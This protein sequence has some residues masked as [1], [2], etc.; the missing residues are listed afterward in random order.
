MSLKSDS[1]CSKAK[2]HQPRTASCK[3]S[4]GSLRSSETR[5]KTSSVQGNNDAAYRDAADVD[6]HDYELQG[7]EQNKRFEIGLSNNVHKTSFA[8][9]IPRQAGPLQNVEP[10]PYRTGFDLHHD[11]VSKIL[12]SAPAMGY[13]YGRGMDL[14]G[15]TSEPSI[16][17]RNQSQY[18][19]EPAW[20]EP[21]PTA[22][23][24]GPE[25]KDYLPSRFANIHQPEETDQTWQAHSDRGPQA[26]K[27]DRPS[28]VSPGETL[29]DVYDS[30]Y[31]ASP[32]YD[33]LQGQNMQDEHWRSGNGE[34]LQS[35]RAPRIA[36]N[37]QFDLTIDEQ[38][39]SSQTELDTTKMSGRGQPWDSTTRQPRAKSAEQPHQSTAFPRP[40][41]QQVTSLQQAR[42]LDFA[43]GCDTPESHKITS[44]QFSA[45]ARNA[46]VEARP[47][48]SGPYYY[49]H[50][51]QPMSVAQNQISGVRRN[52]FRGAVAFQEDVQPQR[53]RSPAL[54]TPSS[55][56]HQTHIL[57]DSHSKDQ[58]RLIIAQTEVSRTDQIQ[59]PGSRA[60]AISHA[61]PVSPLSSLSA[62]PDALPQHPSP[63]RPGLIQKPPPTQAPKPAPVRNYNNR[64]SA[65]Q[66]SDADY[67]ASPSRSQKAIESVPITHDE[68]D[69][70]KMTTKT[71]PSDYKTQLVLAKKMVEAAHVLADE[72]GR[73][74][75]K[76]RNKNREKYIFEAHKLV[77][78]LVSNGYPDAMFYLGDCHSRGLLGLAVDPKDAF[79]LYQS[80]AKAGHAQAAYRVAVCCEMGQEEG[81]GT[82]RDPLKAIQWYKRAATLGDTPAM[83]KMGMI[84]L[85]GLLAQAK[86]PKDAL[87][88]LKRA[89]DRADAENPHALH[90]LVSSTWVWESK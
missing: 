28:V 3:S 85:K 62:N 1:H 34:A 26:L 86:N 32:E 67:Q 37:R 13:E 65:F 54:R 19:G 53:Y 79:I 38:L 42:N 11:A 12:P 46:P 55:N 31:N 50:R 24:H 47:Q 81:G 77:K 71:N 9:Q 43:I 25:E 6:E 14:R 44:Q 23:Y 48:A 8:H 33:Q 74:D 5:R 30:Y 21:G 76:Q 69:L 89:A 36:V 35:H 59:N 80:A 22:G 87:I 41:I 88:W 60:S 83:Y 84:Q 75:Q 4:R 17:S 40:V 72:G 16:K 7:R 56:P 45:K 2:D 39:Q 52:D 18:S 82:R 10:Y 20:L 57:D 27:V 78:K 66:H 68:L 73:A 58:Q 64:P 70:L 49:Q 15:G 51:Q 90:E 29:G 63:V 61:S